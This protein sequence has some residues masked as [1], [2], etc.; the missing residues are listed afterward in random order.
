MS[1][2]GL[3]LKISKF[4]KTKVYKTRKCCMLFGNMHLFG[5]AVMLFIKCND[6]KEALEGCFIVNINTDEEYREI[7]MFNCLHWDVYYV[8]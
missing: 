6:I 2:Q 4:Q 7:Y 5:L 3:D 1:S 8:F